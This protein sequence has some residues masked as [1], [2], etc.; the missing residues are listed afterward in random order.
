VIKILEKLK[1]KTD[2]LSD[3]KKSFFNFDQE[4]VNLIFEILFLFRLSEK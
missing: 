4:N 2:L 1:E 3:L